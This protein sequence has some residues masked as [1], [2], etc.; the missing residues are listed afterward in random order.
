M[1]FWSLKLPKAIGFRLVSLVVLSC[2]LTVSLKAQLKAEDAPAP[3]DNSTQTRASS[4][5]SLKLGTGDLVEMT[6][7]NVPEL[8]TKTRI[9]SNGDM[10][11]PLVGYMHV[12]GLSAE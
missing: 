6:V 5:G 9:S 4:S 3:Q 11:C 2:A 7:Y 12:A 8:T 1:S 10:Y